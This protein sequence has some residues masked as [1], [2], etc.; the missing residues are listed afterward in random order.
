MESCVA[1]EGIPNVIGLFRH[2]EAGHVALGWGGSSLDNNT[3]YCF[4]WGRG[5]VHTKVHPQHFHN[6]ITVWHVDSEGFIRK[7]FSVSRVF[8]LVLFFLFFV[9]LSVYL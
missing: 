2:L 7:D 6:Y 4:P 1:D 5:G 8:V 9:F 3:E